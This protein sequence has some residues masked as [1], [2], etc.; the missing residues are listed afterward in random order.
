MCQ[1]GLPERLAVWIRGSAQTLRSAQLDPSLGLLLIRCVTEQVREALGALISSG[2]NVTLLSNSQSLGKAMWECTPRVPNTACR[3][4]RPQ[5]IGFILPFSSG[6]SSLPAVPSETRPG[7]CYAIS[8]PPYLPIQIPAGTSSSL[9]LPSSGGLGPSTRLSPKSFLR[10]P[11]Q[12]SSLPS[13][14]PWESHTH[15]H[16]CTHPRGCLLFGL[17]PNPERNAKD[18]GEEWSPFFTFFQDP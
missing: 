18:K 3:Q 16:T 10:L 15:P 4:D 5:D 13:L 7:S 9:G 11:C 2:P 14:E 12:C 17:K 6:S 1:A 8:L